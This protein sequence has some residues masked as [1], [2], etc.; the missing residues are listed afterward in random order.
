MARRGDVLVAKRRLGFAVKG[1]EERFVVIQDDDVGRYTP[2]TIAVVLDVA[3][4]VHD[5]SPF[6]VAVTPAEAGS[7][8]PH[9]ALANHVATIPLDRFQPGAVGRLDPATLAQLDSV[10]RVV[11][12]LG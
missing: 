9:L 1:E 8:V 2:T 3:A 12:A 7:R 10:L 6:A 5:G 4:A 11:L